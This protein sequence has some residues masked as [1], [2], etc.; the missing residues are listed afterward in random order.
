MYLKRTTIAIWIFFLI[1]C[2]L[3]QDLSTE[4]NW[5]GGETAFTNDF[6]YLTGSSDQPSLLVR[7]NS[8]DLF[9]GSVER[10]KSGVLTEQ[11]YKE[12]KLHGKSIKKSPDGSWVEANYLDGRLH[13]QIKLYDRSGSLRSIM[14]YS[15]GVLVPSQPSLSSD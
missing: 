3:D 5:I 10:N 2:E 1:S 6:D 9:S 14:N 4:S 8:R 12:G 15:N 7:R 13:G 11:V